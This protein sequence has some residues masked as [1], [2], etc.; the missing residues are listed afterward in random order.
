MFPAAS[1]FVTG[2]AVSGAEKAG[3]VQ[4]VRGVVMAQTDGLVTAADVERFAQAAVRAL[5]QGPNGAQGEDVRRAEV[6]LRIWGEFEKE[7]DRQVRATLF[8]DAVRLAQQIRQGGGS[9]DSAAVLLYQKATAG[10][11]SSL[12]AELAQTV[13]MLG[14]VQQARH[15]GDVIDADTETPGERQWRVRVMWYAKRGARRGA[16]SPEYREALVQGI[17]FARAAMMEPNGL[18]AAEANLAHE[19]ALDVCGPAFGAPAEFGL[20][21][22]ELVEARR[23]RTT[24]G[25][26]HAAAGA[27]KE[28][29]ELSR[30]AAPGGGI[31]DRTGVQMSALELV[32]EFVGEPQMDTTTAWH[33][34]CPAIRASVPTLQLARD[35]PALKRVR[36]ARY[37]FEEETVLVQRVD[38]AFRVLEL[39]E[40]I[41]TPEDVAMV[42]PLARAEFLE[43]QRYAK[44][45]TEVDAFLRHMAALVASAQAA[46]EFEARASHLDIYR[47][48]AALG[49]AEAARAAW[50]GDQAAAD[51]WQAAHDFVNGE[52]HDAASETYRLASKGREAVLFFGDARRQQIRDTGEALARAHTA[53]YSRRA[54]EVRDAADGAAAAVEA[55]ELAGVH[56]VILRIAETK[57]DVSVM[58]YAFDDRHTPLEAFA[59]V[60]ETAA[61]ERVRALAAAVHMLTDTATATAMRDWLVETWMRGSTGADA[62]SAWLDARAA[63][64]ASGAA[65]DAEAAA[66]A[67]DAFVDK[68][69]GTR[70]AAAADDLDARVLVRVALHWHTGA[71]FAMLTPQAT[72]SSASGHDAYV[73]ATLL[74]T[75]RR[76]P[77]EPGAGPA[78]EGFSVRDWDAEERVQRTHVEAAAEAQKQADAR[79]EASLQEHAP[80]YCFGTDEPPENVA[81]AQWVADALANPEAQKDAPLIFAAELNFYFNRT[82][83]KLAAACRAWLERETKTHNLVREAAYAL[84]ECVAR[85]ATA[86]QLRL[87]VG[88]ERTRVLYDAIAGL[89]GMPRG[90]YYLGAGREEAD[91]LAADGLVR[92]LE[93]AADLVAAFSGPS[94]GAEA[95]RL[96]AVE[97]HRDQFASL[98]VEH[99]RWVP[100]ASL[101]LPRAGRELK[102]WPG[103]HVRRVMRMQDADVPASASD[104]R[105]E[106]DRGGKLHVAATVYILRAAR[107]LPAPSA[108][109]MGRLQGVASASSRS[110]DSASA[111][112]VLTVFVFG[113]AAMHRRDTDETDDA[114]GVL[115]MLRSFAVLMKSGVQRHTLSDVMQTAL[116]P[117]LDVVAWLID[118]NAVAPA[119]GALRPDA[120][121]PWVAEPSTLDIV[122]KS[123]ADLRVHSEV[124]TRHRLA[125]L[126]LTAEA[127]DP[128]NQLL[129]DGLRAHAKLWE[130]LRERGGRAAVVS[131]LREESGLSTWSPDEE[132]QALTGDATLFT[133][134]FYAAVGFD[135]L[136]AQTTLAD[137][138]EV[139][140]WRDALEGLASRDV[141]GW[142]RGEAS[143]GSVPTSGSAEALGLY[144]LVAASDAFLARAAKR[145]RA[146]DAVASFEPAGASAKR[147]TL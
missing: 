99:A 113:L 16:V 87:A 121:H 36:E 144:D 80:I 66:E 69:S 130:V 74:K 33:G 68:A 5:V 75:G 126:G 29:V 93:R 40:N 28:A 143:L 59:P 125:M 79:E 101:C 17:E 62:A 107:R 136:A 9:T 103:T 42:R 77:L 43:A 54:Q 147:Q 120:L 2:R 39:L 122:E 146:A 24:A 81:R 116:D 11:D 94:S 52:L 71:V 114:D 83:M 6:D 137:K 106:L 65:A 111:E 86:A 129:L 112:L 70:P 27:L 145:K 14:H 8:R 88:E 58:S 67:L 1:A 100:S 142:L 118:N 61:R 92:A 96:R 25:A 50:S 51:V 133:P 44:N 13:A 19:Y 3:E 124:S 91:A 30:T 108:N 22:M 41:R 72:M 32:H 109:L 139:K 46:R 18:S 117:A 78:L 135:T 64:R 23:M 57:A 49:R 48:E 119:E 10:A 20:A 56:P 34:Y 105:G 82:T 90:P 97:A 38:F 138:P 89:G 98:V 35:A 84:Q 4:I 15:L 55:A 127:Q 131:Q 102:D 26:I 53:V 63:L 128:H 31:P 47:L 115:P 73:S 123:L 141:L 132:T 76:I 37:V 12:G 104:V 140:S 110:L 7:P 134:E 21:L 45:F 85:I 60:P 95:R